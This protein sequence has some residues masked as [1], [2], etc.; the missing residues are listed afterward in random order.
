[1]VDLVF[2]G[3][4]SEYNSL[5]TF[6]ITPEQ[7]GINAAPAAVWFECSPVAQAQATGPAGA[8]VYDP[9]YHEIVYIWDFG[10]PAN[11]RPTTDLN[12]PESW[13]NQNEGRGRRAAHTYNDPGEYTVTCYAYEPATRRFG[14]RQITIEIGDPDSVFGGRQ[15]I[16]YDPN[17][18]A[19]VSGLTN[20][21][22]QL[23]FEGALAARRAIST[24]PARILFANDVTLDIDGA[25]PFASTSD[26]LNLRIGAM[27]PTGR[28][29]VIRTRGR[30]GEIFR[31]WHPE[32]VELML[33]NVEL[34]G[35]WDSTTET[36]RIA[37][38]F[39][40][41]KGT[42]TAPDHLFSLHRCVVS[43]FEQVRG[44]FT[45]QDGAKSYSMFSDTKV[46]DWQNYGITPGLANRTVY[47]AVIGCALT[48]HEDALSGGQKNGLYN[49]HGPYRDFGSTHSYLAASDFFSRNGWSVGGTLETVPEG[50]IRATAVQPALRVNTDGVLGMEFYADRLKVEGHI[51]LK[52][53]P[54]SGIT[55]NPGNHVLDRV[56]QLLPRQ[57][58]W[59]GAVMVEHGG[60][61]CRNVFTVRLNTP[62]YTATT[63]TGAQFVFKDTS[64]NSANAPAGWRV[65]HCTM[66]D[67]RNDANT[68]AMISI[69]HDT[70][71]FTSFIAENNLVHRPALSGAVAVS[72]EEINLGQVLDGVTC[73]DKG[74][75]YGFLHQS[76]TLTADIANGQSLTVPYSQI[77]DML[78]NHNLIDN[79]TPTNQAYWQATASIDTKHMFGVG[80]PV[81]HA[82]H[83]QISVS[84]GATGAIIT[85]TS[86][87]TWPSGQNWRLKLDRSSRL[88]IAY[89]PIYNATTIN[90][91][92]TVNATDPNT[93]PAGALGA[94]A[95]D[96]LRGRERTLADNKRGALL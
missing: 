93:G 14:S 56:L 37:R 77:T 33:Y 85:N 44:V 69:N 64:T 7:V 94:F 35:E 39:S 75:R 8:E 24:L 36:G 23:S 28:K 78:Y 61:T 3:S 32:C 27:Q 96:D 91:D 20:P 74:P 71:S 25:T 45:L 9:Q 12:I 15:T 18:T 83:G 60:A 66:L 52:D 30:D 72:G 68:G 41:N 49:N 22:V 42:F 38:P 5:L 40:V 73:R 54:A 92:V 58:V 48:Q 17:G 86:G 62:Q 63:S 67:L 79:G 47:N 90:L 4:S 10:D 55:S 16:V 88:T 1:M 6:D 46:T 59:N 29:P 87:V 65:A 50:Q 31:D 51:E 11:A 13:K 53:I 70:P 2:R 21:N 57:D 80:G 95:Y 84:F 43:G 82:L 89:A 34:D 76:G 26:M 81:Y 19:D